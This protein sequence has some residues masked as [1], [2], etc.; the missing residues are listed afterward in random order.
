[1]GRGKS[2]KVLRKLVLP[3]FCGWK[4]EQEEEA[5]DEGRKGEGM[6]KEQQRV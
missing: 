2:I 1:M 5:R 4:R 3:L 6:G